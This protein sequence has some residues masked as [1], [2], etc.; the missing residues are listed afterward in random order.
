MFWVEV[1]VES[2]AVEEGVVIFFP[3]YT[4]LLQPQQLQHLLGRMEET[5]YLLIVFPIEV[6]AVVEQ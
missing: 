1:L 6:S 2:F 4:S 3:H 5:C